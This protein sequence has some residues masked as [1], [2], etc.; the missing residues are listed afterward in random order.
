MDENTVTIKRA[1][2]DKVEGPY[3]RGA[4][5]LPDFR[6]HYYT[7]N[8]GGIQRR[9]DK[10]T[11]PVQRLS[12]RYLVNGEVRRY[13]MR[14]VK[15]GDFLMRHDEEDFER[16]R[17]YDLI[18][19]IEWQHWHNDGAGGDLR[20]SLRSTKRAIGVNVPEPLTDAEWNARYDEVV[21][22]TQAINERKPNVYL[23]YTF[24]GEAQ[25]GVFTP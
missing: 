14:D 12:V 15:Y 16:L 1:G 21:I 20:V 5:K 11:Y 8:E 6:H 13:D 19:D 2:S 18:G 24:R 10:D 4:V 17:L 25:R 3:R 9:V 22:R 7:V 23:K